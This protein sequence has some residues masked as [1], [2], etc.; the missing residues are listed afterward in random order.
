MRIT[1]Y[2]SNTF[3][4]FSSSNVGWV[5][6][7]FNDDHFLSYSLTVDNVRTMRVHEDTEI[8]LMYILNVFWI[9]CECVFTTIVALHT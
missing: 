8:D 6:N 4:K 2:L 1:E 7:Y 5:S 3:K 9:E